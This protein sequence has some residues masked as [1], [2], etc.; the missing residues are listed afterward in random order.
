MKSCSA[1]IRA[2]VTACGNM[3]LA[4][5]N[6]AIARKCPTDNKPVMIEAHGT[7]VTLMGQNEE[8][9]TAMLAGVTSPAWISKYLNSRY[10]RFPQAATVR[11]NEASLAGSNDAGGTRTL[12]GEKAYL[13]E[14]A[15]ASGSCKLT[16]AVAHWWIL[17]DDR[18][19]QAD[20]AFIES[21]GHTAA[22]YKD[23]LYELRSGR[24]GIARL[25]QFGIT[26][27][28]RR[29]VIYVEPRNH[30]HRQVGSNTAR[31]HLLLNRQ[32]L[33]WNAWA[34]EF[35]KKLPLALRKLVADEGAARDTDHSLS[36]QR[37][38]SK[39][40]ELFQPRRYR[41][42]AKG[43]DKVGTAPGGCQ[44]AKSTKPATKKARRP[45]RPLRSVVWHARTPRLPMQANPPIS[46]WNRRIRILRPSGSAA[47]T[48]RAIRAFSMTVLPPICLSN[49]CCRSTRTSRCS[50]TRSRIAAAGLS[51]DENVQKL[52]R[53][54][55]HSWFEQA[56]VESVL[57]ML[58]V[59]NSKEWSD[60]DIE[61]ALS[62]ESLTAAV[63]QR[64]HII[65][66]TRDTLRRTLRSLPIAKKPASIQ[67]T[68]RQANCQQLDVAVNLVPALVLA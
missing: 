36:V 38:L 17:N 57:G 55:V 7:E 47:T 44:T 34:A 14:H 25:Q 20:A 3:P 64:Y 21:S 12:T 8:S 42:N 68:P 37:R 45:R 24:N 10:Y 30:K 51:T 43:K 61:K 29:V 5:T 67:A 40:K 48:A 58:A 33:P 26:F 13:D 41:F 49:T 65:G 1:A 9:N 16:G 11:V 18:R 59:R 60:R 27:G 35:S 39:I 66:A 46:R 63:M 50:P 52:I 19:L 32:P 2:A 22:L 54:T 62:S 31:S 23:E 56:L 28:F 15:E 4:T 53:D 6:S